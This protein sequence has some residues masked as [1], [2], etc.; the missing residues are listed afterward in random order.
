MAKTAAT[1]AKTAAPEQT[2]LAT[3]APSNDQLAALGEVF[4]FDL[5]V[6]GLEG[7]DA[8]DIKMPALVFNLKGQDEKTG[9]MR[10]LNEF[11]LTDTEEMLPTVNAI[12][13]AFTKSNRFAVFNDAESK[14]EVICSSYD[15]RTGVMRK[16]HPRL[17]IA[18][19]TERQCATCPDAQW[20]KDDKG[21]NKKNCSEFSNVFAVL[22]NGERDEQGRIPLTALGREFMVRFGKTSWKPFM[23]HLNKHHFKKHPTIRGKDVPLFAYSVQLTLQVQKGGNYAIPV[24]A[25]GAMISR[26]TAQQLAEISKSF[27]EAREEYMR[28]SEKQEEKHAGAIDTEGESSGGGR[29]DDFADDDR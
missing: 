26:E 14:N 9:R 18:P 3:T 6:T 24:L 16:D 25:K 11:M 17:P 8:D 22:D 19:Q 4:D 27:F 12:F 29:R 28:A 1:A 21:K 15:Q 5:E 2:A 10:Q 7:A 23:D 20:V 13:V